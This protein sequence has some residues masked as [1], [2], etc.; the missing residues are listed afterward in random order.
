MPKSFNDVT[1]FMERQHIASF[2]TVDVNRKPHVV[3]VW[4]THDDGKVFVQTDRNSVKVRNIKKNSNVAIAI[5]SAEE[6]VTIR[7]EGRVIE[8]QGEFGRRT[9]QHV[10]KH[11]LKL[12]EQGRD[13]MGIPLYN[14][15]IQCVVEVTPKKVMFW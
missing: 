14:S 13:S 11:N 5:Y 2:A 8:D 4:F 12:D 7:G 10:K 1:D 15:R 3:P 6:A 9:Q